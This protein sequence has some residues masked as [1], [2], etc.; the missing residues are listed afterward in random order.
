MQVRVQE[1]LFPSLFGCFGWWVFLFL[2]GYPR[3]CE[4]HFADGTV[5]SKMVYTRDVVTTEG[6]FGDELV[7]VGIAVLQDAAA[8]VAFD[9]SCRRLVCFNDIYHSINVFTWR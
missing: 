7:E 8:I 2:A 3:G 9:L 1:Y 5:Q 4:C 6:G